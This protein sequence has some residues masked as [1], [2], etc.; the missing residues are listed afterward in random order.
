MYLIICDTLYYYK[1]SKAFSVEV[2]VNTPSLLFRISNCNWKTPI[3][4][5]GPTVRYVIMKTQF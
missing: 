2:Y 3:L 5:T 1:E 4:Q